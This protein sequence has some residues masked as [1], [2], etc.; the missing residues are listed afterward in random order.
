MSTHISILLK[1]IIYVKIIFHINKNII[2]I[3]IY[4]YTYTCI[5]IAYIYVHAICINMQYVRNTYI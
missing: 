1:K 5:Y 4:I 3:Y 2:Y